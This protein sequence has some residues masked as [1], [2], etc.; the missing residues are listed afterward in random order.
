MADISS[1][2]AVEVL[3]G[4]SFV[5]FL[6]STACSAVQ[7]TLASVLGWRAKT[8]EDAVGTMLGNPKVKRG[9]KEWFGR[10]DKKGVIDPKVV[11]EH[12]DAGLPPEFT[13]LTTAVFE[14]WRIKGLVRDPDSTLRRRCRPSYLP[15]RALSLAV[16]ETLALHAPPPPPKAG[17]KQGAGESETPWQRTDDEILAAVQKVVKQLPGQHPRE[18]LQKAAV[19][20]HGDLE[21]F[22][23]Q[24]ERA[25]DDS[26]E[27]ASGWY[28]RK[29]QFVLAVLALLF[30]VGLNIDSVRIA[31]HLYNDEAV[32][33]AV[34]NQAKTGDP[35]QAAEAVSDITELQLP[36]GWGADNR[37]EGLAAWAGAMAGW[38]IT[39]AALLLG[40]PFWF[41]LLSRLSR[42]RGVGIPEKPGRVLS[43]K[44][45]ADADTAPAA[46][47]GTD[48]APADAG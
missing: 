12:V 46:K 18:V 15:P 7:E 43:D 10:V 28:K 1:F 2:A 36:V 26:M 21:G 20:A 25:F 40:A 23:K 3:I 24:V 11:E 32:R 9:V 48:A 8:L 34:V 38:L 29:A 6:L 31:N 4:L 47:Q 30:A 37:P 45:V 39:I 14:H 22:R 17:A 44:P 27:R 13:D 5:F 19:N 42:Q 41:D 33:T 16:A 35:K